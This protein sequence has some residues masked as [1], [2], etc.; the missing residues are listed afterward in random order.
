MNPAGGRQC[1]ASTDVGKMVAL[2]PF[3]ATQQAIAK[4]AKTIAKQR[5]IEP[6]A[7]GHGLVRT[8]TACMSGHDGTSRRA[9]RVS[10][11]WTKDGSL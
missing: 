9:G 3:G 11:T 4:I 10:V 8:G 6:P 2:R 7:R 5:M 1:N